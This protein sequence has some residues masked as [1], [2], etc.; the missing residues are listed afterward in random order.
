LANAAGGGVPDGAGD[1]GCKGVDQAKALVGTRQ[2]QD[3]AIGTD[4]GRIEG[5][6]DMI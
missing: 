4:L 6:G 5:G 1:E 3:T 2:E